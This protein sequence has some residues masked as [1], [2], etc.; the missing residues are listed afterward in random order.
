MTNKSHPERKTTLSDQPTGDDRNN[1]LNF[2]ASTVEVILDRMAT[3][4]DIARLDY[5]IDG[6]E[7]RLD[8][9]IDGLE[10]RVNGLDAKIDSVEARLSEKIDVKIKSVRGDI[11]QVHLRLGSIERELTSRVAHM[12]ADVSRLRSVLYLLVKEDPHLL[13]VLG[14]APPYGG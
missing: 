2:I 9:K 12:E 6:V 4:D 1:L 8:A 14:Y 10:S 5:K 7:A 11:E 13:R 3:K